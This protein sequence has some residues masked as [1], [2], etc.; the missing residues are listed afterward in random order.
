MFP[1][2]T[3]TGK[4]S[5]S[6]QC[7]QGLKSLPDPE[8]LKVGGEDCLD[9]LWLSRDPDLPAHRD[10]RKRVAHVLKTSNSIGEDLLGFEHRDLMFEIM[11]ADDTLGLR[12]LRC[13]LAAM[14]F[15]KAIILDKCEQESEKEEGKRAQSH[16]YWR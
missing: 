10:D 1:E 14:R 15:G 4:Y 2:R 9:V 5:L 12:H 13:L 11:V 3:V 7:S 16:K 8:V 6:Q